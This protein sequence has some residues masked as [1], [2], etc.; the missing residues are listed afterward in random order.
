M[1]G[2]EVLV[3]GEAL[4]E[5]SDRPVPAAGATAIDGRGRTLM[6]GPVDCHVPERADR[7]A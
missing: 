6:P 4:R 3:E 7:L 2:H 1:G 5:V